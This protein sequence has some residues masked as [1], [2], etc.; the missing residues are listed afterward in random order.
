MQA[1]H[2]VGYDEPEECT[3][4]CA[5]ELPWA[6]SELPQMVISCKE[7]LPLGAGDAFKYYKQYLQILTFQSPSFGSTWMLKC[8]F[9]LAYLDALHKEF[10][11]STVV[12]THRNPVKFFGVFRT[13]C[14]IVCMFFFF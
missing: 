13:P 9:H 1:I 4:P 6:V 3:T 10:P 8:P 2:R 11:N 12:W 7:V 5:L 14:Y